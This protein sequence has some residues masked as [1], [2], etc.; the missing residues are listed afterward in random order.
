M[1]INR[2]ASHQPTRWRP[3]AVAVLAAAARAVL[4]VTAGAVASARAAMATAAST[5]A[6]GRHRVGWWLAARLMVM[7]GSLL[8]GPGHM[9]APARD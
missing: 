5:A 4:A 9:P 8:C 1:T 7:A 6:I 2:A 3:M